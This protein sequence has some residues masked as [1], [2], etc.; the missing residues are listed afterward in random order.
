M[1]LSI[2]LAGLNAASR[3]LDAAAAQIAQASNPAGDGDSDV[4]TVP[5]AVAPDAP[6]T[7]VPTG[8]SSGGTAAR[9]DLAAAMV[10]QISASAAFLANLQT[11]RR[12]DDAQ[13]ALLDAR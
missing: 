10:E 1:N 8:T 11:I 9:P 12:E 7:A 5:D 3:R 6:G 13:R 2:G 4:D